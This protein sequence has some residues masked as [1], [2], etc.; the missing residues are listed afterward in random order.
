MNTKT[1]YQ[2]AQACA[3]SPNR[4]AYNAGALIL[5]VGG[6]VLLLLHG[7][8]KV[9]LLF[10]GKPSEFLNPLGLGM[11]VSLFLAAFAEVVCALC[12]VFGVATRVAA[13]LIV[14][15]MAVAIYAVADK[16]WAGQELATVYLLIF[17]SVVCLG[18]GAWSVA[19]CYARRHGK[20][21]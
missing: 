10:S 12:V 18:S 1:L 3:L 7:I 2:H 8:P 13:T 21:G 9:A 16:G 11:G 4:W 15:N 5:R 6:G 14:V 19:G 20:M 17:L